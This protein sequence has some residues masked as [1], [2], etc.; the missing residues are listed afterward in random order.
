VR[1]RNIIINIIVSKHWVS[2]DRKWIGYC[3]I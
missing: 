3:A 1:N 2:Q